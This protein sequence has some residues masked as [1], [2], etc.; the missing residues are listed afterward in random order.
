MDYQKLILRFL[1]GEISN[2]EITS[3]K[4]WLG[5]NKENRRIFNQENELWQE[6]SI[7]AKINTFNARTDWNN[8]SLSLGL[9][10]NGSQPFIFLK[11]NNYRILLV[12]ASIA[13]LTAVVGTSLWLS[14]RSLS[15]QNLPRRR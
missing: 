11:K 3:L 2:E 14:E 9:G 4:T 1:A 13:F 8:I 15:R 10:K 12:A 7:K 5:N 6:S